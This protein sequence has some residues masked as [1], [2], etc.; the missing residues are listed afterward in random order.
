MV[1]IKEKNKWFDVILKI[2][3]F[4]IPMYFIFYP[5]LNENPDNPRTVSLWKYTLAGF[6][7]YIILTLIYF[8]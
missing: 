7:G 5:D 1:N 4:L 8:T 6:V 2:F 3:A